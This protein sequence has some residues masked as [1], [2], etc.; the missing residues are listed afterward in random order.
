MLWTRLPEKLRTATVCYHRYMTKVGS[1]E[2]P[3]NVE[4]E[5]MDTSVKKNCP[6][7]NNNIRLRH[8]EPIKKETSWIC[9]HENQT[10]LR[11]LAT[12]LLP[13]LFGYSEI[14]FHV[15]MSAWVLCLF[16]T[17]VGFYV[18]ECVY[19]CYYVESYE[20]VYGQYGFLVNTNTIPKI[21]YNQHPNMRRPHSLMLLLG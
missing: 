21:K 11:K 5:K 12:Q 15:H 7:S 14:V 4:L 17:S 19:V 13:Y 3:M 6:H 20:C 16:Y 8:V 9:A 2:I 18:Y 10:N 1:K